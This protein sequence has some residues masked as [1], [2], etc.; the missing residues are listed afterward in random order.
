MNCLNRFVVSFHADIEA[1]VVTSPNTISSI[2]VETGMTDAPAVWSPMPSANDTVDGVI[3]P[4]TIVCEVSPGNVVVS[5]DIFPVGTT[6]VT[7]RANDTALNEGSSQFD[8]TVLGT[9]CIS[10]LLSVS[11]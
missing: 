1:P 10:V 9:Y 7:C 6:T 2:Y 11:L 4:S 3:D 5:G 8:V